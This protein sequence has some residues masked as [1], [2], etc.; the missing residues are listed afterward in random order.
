M[1][2]ATETTLL[3]IHLDILRDL[4]V[5]NLKSEKAVTDYGNRNQRPGRGS[6]KYRRREPA[7]PPVAALKYVLKTL[8]FTEGV[9]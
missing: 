7:K 5:E 3:K 8:I 2:K 6:N 4:A 1:E 9:K